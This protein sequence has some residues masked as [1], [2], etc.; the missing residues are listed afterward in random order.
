MKSCLK[1]RR[2]AYWS[3]QVNRCE[4][5]YFRCCVNEVSIRLGYEALSVDDVQ[6]E[7]LDVSTVE[8]ET[9]MQPQ[10]DESVIS[11]KNGYLRCGTVHI[12]LVWII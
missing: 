10:N 3:Q 12:M 1:N 5:L 6:E 7:V 2:R 4:F 9:T 8:D 11:Q